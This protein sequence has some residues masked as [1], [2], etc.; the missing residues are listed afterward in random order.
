MRRSSAAMGPGVLLD[1]SSE[2]EEEGVEED[3]LDLDETLSRTADPSLERT[4]AEESTV[5]IQSG[6]GTRISAEEMEFLPTTFRP[7]QEGDYL[8][9]RNH[10]LTRWR[11]APSQHLSKQAA[12]ST[13]TS[14]VRPLASAAWSFLTSYGYINFGQPT[15]IASQ[16]S[17]CPACTVLVIGAGLAGLAA[18]KHLHTLGHDAHLLEARDRAGGR[19]HTVSFNVRCIVE[20]GRNDCS[21]VKLSEQNGCK[22]VLGAVHLK[23]F[24]PFNIVG[25]SHLQDGHSCADAGGSIVYGNTGNP[26]IDIANQIGQQHSTCANECLIC[27]LHLLHLRLDSTDTTYFSLL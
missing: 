23:R 17:E 9:A 2:E 8:V 25:M 16:A 24:V 12:L 18:G 13:I 27:S 6:L 19:V 7:K 20:T 26:L 10:I 21:C 4:S 5:A 3:S 11:A 14:G 15:Q 1:G 22:L